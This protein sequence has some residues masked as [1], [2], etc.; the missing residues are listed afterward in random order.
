MTV[1][2]QLGLEPFKGCAGLGTQHGSS[3]RWLEQPG[4]TGYLSVHGFPTW[5]SMANS[6]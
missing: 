2:L 1:S 4:L 6:T 3:L 5:H